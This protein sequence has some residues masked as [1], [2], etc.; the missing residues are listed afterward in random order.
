MNGSSDTPPPSQDASGAL[1]T[2]QPEPSSGA[3]RPSVLKRLGFVGILGVIALFAPPL[4]SIALFATMGTTGPWLRGHAEIGVV[5]Y[6]IAFAVL[7]GLALLPTYAQSALGGFAFGIVW[8]IPAALLGFAGGAAIGYAVA[9]RASGDR[10]QK[11]IDEKPK[12]R[13]V[14]DALMDRRKSWLRTT[15]MVALVRLPPNSP[16]AIM[17]LLMASVKVP[18]SSFIVGTVVGMLPRSSLAVIIGAGV[19]NLTKD[20]LSARVPSWVWWTGIAV[21]VV[22]VMAIGAIADRAIKRVTGVAGVTKSAGTDPA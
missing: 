17:N 10:V 21:T 13:A 3:P 22:I 5:I 14:R 1:P 12:A 15:M 19:D 16:F 9:S 18:W 4:G 11:L 2:A 20:E 6:V 8:G 7:A